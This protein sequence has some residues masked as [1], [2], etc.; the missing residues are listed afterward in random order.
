M[1]LFVACYPLGYPTC[2]ALLSTS[3]N[4][5]GIQWLCEVI[6]FEFIPVEALA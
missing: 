3:V 5:I 1:L 2:A 4:K 6:I